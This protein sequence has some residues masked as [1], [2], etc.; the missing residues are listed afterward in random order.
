MPQTN[1]A[2]LLLMDASVRARAQHLPM[3]QVLPVQGWMPRS[4]I[5]NAEHDLSDTQT[6]KLFCGGALVSGN[7]CLS[8]SERPPASPSG[9]RDSDAMLPLNPAQS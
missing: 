9:C 4:F 7:H 6:H 8:H 5:M 3:S 1:K 2:L